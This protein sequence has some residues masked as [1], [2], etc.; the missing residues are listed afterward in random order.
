MQVNLFKILAI[1]A[2]FST[3]QSAP[4][5][6]AEGQVTREQVNETHV[7]EAVVD[8]AFICILTIGLPILV[9]LV[10]MT[11]SNLSS[12]QLAKNNLGLC[13][14]ALNKMQKAYFS[15]NAAYKL[16]DRA[17][18][19]VEKRL[20]EAEVVSRDPTVSPETQG[21]ETAQWLDDSEDYDF[22]STGMLSA[23]WTPFAN[24]IP[25][26]SFRNSF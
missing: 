24:F 6:T 4:V 5:E 12:I 21:L 8:D 9:Y 23:S 17:R 22:A 13:L 11:S 26:D 16:F 10:E 2:A 20:R 18:T 7:N 25:D 15:A 1:T 14:L 19:M 3:V